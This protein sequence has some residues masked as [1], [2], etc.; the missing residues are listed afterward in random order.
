MLNQFLSN[1]S[2]T[3]IFIPVILLIFW[4]GDFFRILPEVFE[5]T[6]FYRLVNRVFDGQ[7]FI[8]HLVGFFFALLIAFMV[9]RSF[10]NSDFYLNENAI[11]SLVFIVLI[12]SW[13]GFHFFS[14]M[15]LSFILLI[16]SIGRLL[17]VYHQKNVLRE[18]FDAGF[19]IGVAALF[20]YPLLLFVISIWSL[21]MLSRSFNF[22]EYAVPLI[23]LITPFY[24]LWVYLFFTDTP[25]DFFDYSANI[26]QTSL[27]YNAG[28]AQRFFL[29]ITGIIFLLSFAFLLKILGRSKVRVQIARKLLIV[30]F[31]NSALIYGLSFYYYPL[32]ER[33][34][35]LI[36]PLV[37]ILPF[38]F[39]E[40]KPFYK[41][42]AFYFWIL[43]ALLF[44]YFLF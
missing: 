2:S 7:P 14:P 30:L 25:I 20:Y 41:N 31:F 35:I 32:T 5:P 1:R 24:F 4:M 44:D 9:N 21:L 33:A 8:S 38:F 23:G 42:L 18:L 6:F 16:L 34:I 17:M 37:Y 26:G 43:S 40:T 13:Q 15:F 22:R 27:I 10:N 28:L 39:F 11:S 3:V 29:V 36:F 19:L 12:G